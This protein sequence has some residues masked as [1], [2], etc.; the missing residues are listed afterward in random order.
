MQVLQFVTITISSMSKPSSFQTTS[1]H[2]A[3]L[4]ANHNTMLA[5]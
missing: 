2:L 1:T 3:V 5:N 4:D